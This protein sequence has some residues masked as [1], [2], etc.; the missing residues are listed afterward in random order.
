MQN[1]EHEIRERAYHMWRDAGSP[2]GN[3]DAFWL[4]AQREV[5]AGSLGQIASVK[6]ATPKAAAKPKAAPRKRKVA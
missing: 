4:A 6:A 3:S 2:V 5:L 1:M